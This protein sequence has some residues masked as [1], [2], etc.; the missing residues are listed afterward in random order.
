[1]TLFYVYI[2]FYIGFCIELASLLSWVVMKVLFTLD[3][4][5]A[6]GVPH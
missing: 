4:R 1:M 5:D 2:P 6:N 3:V